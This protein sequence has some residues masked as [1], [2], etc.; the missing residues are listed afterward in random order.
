MTAS[1]YG[2]ELPLVDVNLNPA[3]FSDKLTQHSVRQ[4]FQDSRGVL[5]F[6]TQ[7]GLNKYNGHELE[8]Y[9]HSASNPRS[10]PTNFITRITE[11][12]T[13]NIWLSTFGRGLV[14]Y[15]S[16][17]NSFE[18]IDADP[19]NR[20]TP[21]SNNIHTVFTDSMGMLWLGYSN[22]FSQFNP[23]DRSF[24]H[25]ISGN[26]NIPYTGEIGSFTETPDGTIWAATESTGL[27][28]VNPQQN[29]VRIISKGKSDPGISILGGIHRIIT[30]R[31]GYIW[32]ASLNAGIAK[33]DPRTESATFFQHSMA[34]QSSLSSNKVSDIF[35]DMNG[36]IWVATIEGLNFYDKY[37]EQFVRYTRQNTNLPEDIVIS[38]Y[39]SQEK[40]YW[41]GTMSGLA[42]GMRTDFQKFDQAQGNLSNNS[43]NAFAETPDESLWVG[44]DDGLN[45]LRPESDSFTWINES[46]TPSISDP[47]VMS[48]YSDDDKLWV[49]T[50]E[51]GL[52]ELD[53]TSG[54]VTVH[55][56]SSL[57]PNSIGANG[58]TSMLRLSTGQFLVGTYGGGLSILRDDGITFLNLTHDPN[59]N[60]SLSNNE[61]LAI[62]EDSL[63]F[64]WIGTE[65]GLN[66]LDIQTLEFTRFFADPTDSDSLSS[67]MPWCFWEDSDGTLWIGTAGGGINLWPAQSRANLTLAIQQFSE[68]MSLP[69]SN[70]YGIQ[71]DD[72]GW[73]WVSHNK[74]LTRINP[75]DLEVHQ[76]GVRDGLQASEFTLGASFRSDSG[77]IYFGGISGFNTVHPSELSLE[78]VPPKIAISQIKVMNQRRE[79]ETPYHALE[80]IELGY[81]DRML[82][83]EFFAADYSSPDL[84]N[85]AYKLEGINP[86][87]VISPDSRVASFTTLPPGTYTL[88][89]AAASPD[90]TWN[91]DGLSLP[92][93][94]APPPWR[95]NAAYIVYSIVAIGIIAY[96]FYRQRRKAFKA[97]EIQR[98]LETRV[99][100]R[101]K[102][103]EEARKIA[104]DATR[105]KSDFLA[106][107]S[108]E[109][110][111]P[112]HGIIGM[113]ELLLHTNL[114]SQQE[115]FANAAH[116][117][118]ESLLG[119]INEILDF[120]KVEASKVELESVE[121]NLTELIDDICYL[122]S[123]PATRKGLELNNICHP[124]TPYLLLGDPTKLRQVIMN[125]V[126]NSIKFTH[127][128]NINV[129]IEPKFS[130]STP[131]R[132][133]VYIS[134]EDDGIGM[135]E[136]TQN[137][138]F[139]PFTQADTS[140]TRE[141][142]GTGLGLSI[143]RHYI[144]LMGGDIIVNSAVGKG[145]KITLSMP[146]EIA[147]ETT[148]STV[149]L[150]GKTA[151][152]LTENPYV[153]EMIDSHL[154]RLRISVIQ[155]GREGI[156]GIDQK[157][158]DLLV[159]DYN[160]GIFSEIDAQ[161]LNDATGKLNILLVPINTNVPEAFAGKWKMLSKPLMS[162]ALQKLLLADSL[163]ELSTGLAPADNS[164]AATPRLSILVA[165]DVETNQRIVMEMLQI[166]GYQVEIAINGQVALNKF[167]N[168]NYSLVF[169][170][171]QMPVLDGYESTKK[172]REFEQSQESAPTPI[173]A[174]TAGSDED[175]RRRCEASG[176]DAY[177]NK[178]FSLA[179]I[180][181]TIESLLGNKIARPTADSK[182]F[183]EAFQIVESTEPQETENSERDEIFNLSAIESIKEVERQTGKPILDSIFEGYCDQMALKLNE[184]FQHV[185][186]N[187][188]IEA[189]RAAHAIKSMSANIGA[190]KVRT[191]SA[192]IEKL[193][194]AGKME[195][196]EDQVEILQ[197]SY[198]S[199]VDEFGSTFV[200]VRQQ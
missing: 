176:M 177:I 130:S 96:Y 137:R 120:S 1:T 15:N 183:V 14:F 117:S 143:S 8:S 76:Y 10:L 142:G 160:Q 92:I 80:S 132:A 164:K 108:H 114:N 159:V 17:S 75:V 82:S 186:E 68:K 145:T 5:W 104:E 54:N 90:G 45:R 158:C 19:N 100:E 188:S 7:E 44:T 56:H 18:A 93:I 49:G 185:S 106:T 12:K 97:L 86:E 85:Y 170:D 150:S 115:Q 166:L 91:W 33:F 13:G 53:L 94:V 24:H 182:S 180:E 148:Q 152:V 174:L 28:K 165:E 107:M 21:Y 116:K 52:N 124:D 78:R 196:I 113:T 197:A 69:S 133:L 58:I 194:K 27:L 77:T 199:F 101:T 154:A 50:Y 198:L 139:E 147:K 119:L 34:D 123:E 200:E 65:N 157:E 98:E 23:T 57:R 42:S 175:D 187:D 46:T 79:F 167:K 87:W 9:R 26:G 144:E 95:S 41:V 32:L 59:S 193:S 195:N 171:C 122:Q 135:D 36:D 121:F 125:L 2:A 40:K 105:A 178:P 181:K 126:S 111:T 163:T 25:Y 67:D 162:S 71:G 83:V 128:G 74:G 156:F 109:I 169:M 22:G 146:F 136:D 110:R 191:I 149:D 47:R 155:I 153:F 89:L 73:V 55:R 168:G 66:K 141:Y 118:G 6:V 48:L 134:V 31:S 99:E 102:D 190:E 3:V 140:T 112:M 184:L 138:V 37:S 62:Y 127:H 151:I 43:V 179:D 81:Q 38:V 189:S 173:V 84:I 72:N 29:Q 11:D 131:E 35:E 60:S 30:D 129:R 51:G 161:A 192:D 39:Q 88:R 103:L 64:V 61:V 63:G 20:E 172:I 4:S 16:I 70:I